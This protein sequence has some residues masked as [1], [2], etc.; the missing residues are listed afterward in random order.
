MVGGLLK[1]GQHEY[2]LLHLRNA[3]A[4]D[5]EH[6]SLERHGITLHNNAQR[7]VTPC[8]GEAVAS[9]TVAEWEYLE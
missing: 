6:F 9:S 1:R 8:Q 5:A 3:E 4:R 2:A 7:C